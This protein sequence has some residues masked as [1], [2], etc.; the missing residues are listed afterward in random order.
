MLL[1]QVNNEI[2][3]NIPFTILF[4]CY[5]LSCRIREEGVTTPYW[6]IVTLDYCYTNIMSIKF[7]MMTVD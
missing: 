6:G 3:Y 2:C 4:G 5:L 1:L 7:T